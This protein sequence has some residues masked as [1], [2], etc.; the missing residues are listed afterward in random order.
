MAIMH[1]KKNLLFVGSCFPRFYH[2]YQGQPRN[3]TWGETMQMKGQCHKRSKLDWFLHYVSLPFQSWVR[4]LG[5]REALLALLPEICLMG[6]CRTFTCKAGT[7]PLSNMSI[8]SD[9]G[10]FGLTQEPFVIKL[11]YSPSTDA[12]FSWPT[13]SGD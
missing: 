11:I 4:G 5:Q 9:K 7:L 12:F 13:Q 3:S 2:L 10:T 1:H 6:D 8:P